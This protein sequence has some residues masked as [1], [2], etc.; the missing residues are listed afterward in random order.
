MNEWLAKL[1]DWLY[2]APGWFVVCIFSI[3][4]GYAL[5]AI[6]SFPNGG[7]PLFIIAIASIGNMFIAGEEPKGVGHTA[8]MARSFCIGAICGF[9]AWR[10]H[11]K[12]LSKYEDGIPILKW[13]SSSGDTQYF[14]KPKEKEISKP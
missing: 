14:T 9:L 5:R 4:V 1:V 2:Q 11:K 6:P 7:I 12:I 8:W 10:F 13:I 3:V